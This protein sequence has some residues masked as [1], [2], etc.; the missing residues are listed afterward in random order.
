MNYGQ[1]EILLFSFSKRKKE[2]L[3]IILALKGIFN[4]HGF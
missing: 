4:K 1:F 2:V 3:S